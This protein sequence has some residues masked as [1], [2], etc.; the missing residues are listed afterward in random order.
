MLSKD[1]EAKA[2]LQPD[3]VACN[4][5]ISACEKCEKWQH[6]CLLLEEAGDFGLLPNA[7]YRFLAGTMG[8]E[9]SI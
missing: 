4:A 3:V 8:W 2:L 6:A 7:S 9:D 5:V 1:S